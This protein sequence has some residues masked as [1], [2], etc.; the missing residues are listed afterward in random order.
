MNQDVAILVLSCDKYS[1]A[2]NPF[3]ALYDKFWPDRPYTTYLAT[4]VERPTFP[5][6]KILNAGTPRNWS[7]D[8]LKILRQIPE[9]YIIILLE[10]YFLN[11]TP[12][13]HWL[14]QCISVV[15]KTDAS[16]M[17]IASFRKDH[18]PM[19]RFKELPEY[20]G[21]GVTKKD[22]PFLI[23]LQAGIWNREKLMTYILPGE[24][25]WDFETKG[26]RRCE[27]TDDLFLGITQASS[28]DIIT[29]PIPYLCTAITKGVW[30]REAI[31]LC[32]SNGIDINSKQ[33]PVESPTA[34]LSR[35]LKHTFSYNSRRY[36]DFIRGKMG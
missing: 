5:N 36:L 7:D 8:T 3:F 22:A 21:F 29:C 24:S 23:N 28:K 19:Y 2:W 26:S 4:N 17:R 33:R 11:D 34:Y 32:K 10:D 1:D 12:D 31:E 15:R 16:F 18:F 30:M 25:P 20:P 14:E 13:V 6:V 27:K 9:K 35:K